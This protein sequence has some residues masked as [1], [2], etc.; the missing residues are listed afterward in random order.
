[1]F[2][3]CFGI[4]SILLGNT[5]ES[6]VESSFGEQSHTTASAST[7]SVLSIEKGVIIEEITQQENGNTCILIQCVF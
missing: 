6:P 5:D 1:M 4:R 7:V 2:Y 3:R